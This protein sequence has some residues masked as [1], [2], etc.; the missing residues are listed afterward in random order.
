M[1]EAFAALTAAGRD[2]RRLRANTAA[3]AGTSTVEKP[4]ARR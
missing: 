1:I 4:A 2:A 3:A